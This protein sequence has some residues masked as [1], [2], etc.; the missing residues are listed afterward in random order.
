MQ[1]PHKFLEI[2]QCTLQTKYLLFS[3]NHTTFVN[4]SGPDF[5]SFG[6]FS[7][8]SPK[9]CNIFIF[10]THKPCTL[11]NIAVTYHHSGTNMNIKQNFMKFTLLMQIQNGNQL[12]KHFAVHFHKLS[13]NPPPKN[14]LEI[15]PPIFR[16]FLPRPSAITIIHGHRAT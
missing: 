5:H 13:Q 7:A 6:V 9:K 15:F 11:L 12:S 10:S 1:I 16:G 4:M 2:S 14:Q 8:E 3:P